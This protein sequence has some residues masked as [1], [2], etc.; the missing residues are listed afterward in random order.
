MV[1]QALTALGIALGMVLTF[2]PVAAEQRSDAL[3]LLNSNSDA[4][5]DFEHF[6]KPWL[7]HFG[8]P[9]TALDIAASSVE[10]TIGDHAVI[11][12]S[13]RRLDPLHQYL[14]PAEETNLSNAINAGTGLVNFDN[15]LSIDA[16]TPRYAFVQTIFGFGYGGSPSGAGVSFPSPGAHYITERHASGSSFVTGS[17][18]LAGITLPGSV[19]TVAT[20]DSGPFLAVTTHGTGRAVQW[21]SYDWMSYSVK[22]PM[23]GLDDLVWR[24][25]VWAA[26]KPF[27]M[28]GL[29]PFVTLRMDDDSGPF[30]WIH[31]ANEFGI[32]PYTSVFFHDI[33][34]SEAADLSALTHAG[35]ATV[36]I[37]AFDY[38]WFF[39][40]NDGAGT[41]YPDATIDDYFAEGTAWHLAKNIPISKYVIPHKY[42]FGS[43]VLQGLSDWGVEFILTSIGPDKSYGDSWIMNGPFRRYEAGGSG[44]GHPVYYADFIEFPDQPAFNGRFFNCYT[45]IRDDATY[46]WYPNMNDVPGT[47][48]RG[49]RQT[50]RAL[51]AMAL[52]ALFTHAPSVSGNWGASGADNWRA[53]LAGITT[54]LAPYSPLYVTTDE[55][56]RYIRA[57]HNSDISAAVYDPEFNRLTATFSGTTDMPTKFYV[58]GGGGGGAITQVLIDVPQFSGSTQVSFDVPGPLSR[59]DVSPNPAS[60][61]AGGAQQ[62]AAA[63]YDANG[64]PIPNLQFTWGVVNGGGTIDGSGRFTAGATFGT[65]TNTVAASSGG[66]QGFATVEVRE[67]VL[68]HFQFAQITGPKY[69]NAPFTVTITARDAAGNQVPSF[70]GSVTLTDTTGTVT[71]SSAGPF[72]GGVWRG[73]ATIGAEGTGVALTATSGDFPGVSNLFDVV[74]A[75]ACSEFARPTATVAVHVSETT[76]AHWS[77]LSGPHADWQPWH[78][79]GFLMEELR[80]DGTPFDVVSDVDIEAGRLMNGASPRYAILFS[81][82]NDCI[83]DAA[84][85]RVETFVG[86]G[87]HAF[88]GSTS[89]T[90]DGNCAPRRSGAVPPIYTPAQVIATAQ[91]SFGGTLLPGNTIDN[92]CSNNWANAI[93]D[94][95]PTWIQYEFPAAHTLSKVALVHST[96][97]E[98]NPPWRYLVRDYEVQVSTT[99]GCPEGSFVTVAI[100]TGNN[101]PREYQETTFAPAAAKCVRISMLYPSYETSPYLSYDTAHWVMINSFQAFEDGTGAPLIGHSCVTTPGSQMFALSTEMGLGAGDPILIG[102]LKRTGV[103]DPLVSHLE[104]DT[105][106]RGWK[107]AKNSGA[108]SYDHPQH[109]ALRAVPTTATVLATTESGDPILAVQNHGAGRFIYHSEFNPLAGYSMHTVAN[110]VYGFYR[111]AID[112]A[113]A[114]LGWPNVRLGAW[115]WPKLAGFITRHDH[116]SNFGFDGAPGGGDDALVAEIEAAHGVQG[117]HFLRT[118]PALPDSGAPCTDPAFGN[119]CDAAVRANILQMAALGAQFGS[120]TTDETQEPPE[121]NV[122]ASLDRLQA[123]LGSR[124]TIFVAP[125]GSGERDTTAQGLVNAGI[126]AKG[127]I[128]HGAHPHFM[129]KVDTATE[130]GAV[131]R[132]PLVDM[133]ATGYY[134]TPGGGAFAGGIWAH[135]ITSNPAACNND[136]TVRPCMQKAADLQYALGGLIN[137]YDHIGDLSLANPTPAQFGA[138][139]DY[140]QA[141]PY[142]DTT[143]PL[144]LRTWWL[145][146]DPVRV[147]TSY[148]TTPRRIV[149]VDLSC[150]ADPGPF[151][152]EVDLPWSG[153]GIVTVDGAPTTNAVID[154]RRLR[155]SAPAPARVVIAERATTCQSDAE[156]DDLDVCNGVESCNV[157]S[158]TC[159]PGT[160][161]VCNDGN[162]CTDDT[163]NGVLG[164]VFTNNQ[165]SCD[166]G[167]FCN[168]ADVCL[169]GACVH[170]TA[171]CVDPALCDEV[172]DRCLGGT[173]EDFRNTTATVAV[174]VSETTKAQWSSLG[175]PHADWQS[176]HVYGFLMEELRSDGTPFDV[177]SDVDIEAGRLMNGASPRYAILFSLAN[178]CISDAAAAQVEAFVGAGGHA[179]VGSTSWTRDGSCNLR[180]GGN[181]PPI[182]TPAQVSVT[183]QNS[184]GSTFLPGNTIDNNCN[185][186]WAN[187]IGDTL[188]TWIQY[189]FPAV[190]TL[191]KIA[192]VHSTYNET[193]PPWRYLVRNYEVQV[194]TTAGCPDGSFV[195]V[196]T[197]TGN[198]VPREYQ[199]TSFAP[200]A[201][202]CVRVNML[203]PSYETSPYQTYNT[204]N[205][206]MINSFQAF[207][208]GSGARLIDHSCATPPVSGLFALSTAM[209]LGAGDPILI[210]N[211]KRTGVVNPL[212]SHLENDTVVR[213]WKL[214]KNSGASSYDHP[215]HWA[216]KVMP[217]TATVLATTGSGDPILTVRNHGA[218]RFIYHSEF[219][220][221]AGYSMH[222]VANLVYGFYRK[223]ID[224]AHAALGWPSVRL[225]A[226]PW[227]KVAGFMTRHDHFAN[228]GFDGSAGTADDSDVALIEAARGVNG[229]YFLRTDTALPNSG[230]PCTD[231]A[232][233]NTCDAAAQASLLN[234]VALGAQIGSHTT[235]ESQEPSQTNVVAS[236]DRLQAYLGSR[237]TIFV[238]PGGS[239]IR[240][241]TNQGLVN[242]GIVTKGDISHGVHPHFTLKIDSATE[243]G[244]AAR[245]PLV[246]MPAT[247][248]YGTPGGGGFAGG[249]WAHEITSNPAGCNNDG[250][251][252]PCMQKAADLQYTLGGLINLYDHIGDLS[253]AN[254]TPAQFGAYIDYVQAKPYVDTTS[255][256]EL[257][258]WWLRRDPVRVTTV[259]GATG[260]LQTITVFVSCASDPGP[261][262][263]EIDLP[264]AGGAGVSVGGVPSTNFVIDGRRIRISSPAPSKVVI[265]EACQNDGQ[266]DDGT[267]CNGRE[268]CSNG[269]CTA[270]T[271]LDC[272]DGDACTTDTCSPVAG[273]QHTAICAVSGTVYYYR[274]NT[275]SAGAGGEPSVKGVENVGIG[276]IA[277]GPALVTTGGTGA[278]VTAGLH[279]NVTITSVNKYG[280]PRASD[281]RGA[282]TALDAARLAMTAVGNGSLSVN[283]KFAGDV[284]GNGTTSALDASLVARFAAGLVDHFPVTTTTASDWKFLKCGA[285]YPL[286]CVDPVY[287]F[288]PITQAETGKDLYAI[289][290]GDVTGN[291]PQVEARAAAEAGGGS[292]A[293]KPSEP[294]SPLSTVLSMPDTAGGGPGSTVF[295]PISATPG[296]GILGIDMMIRYDP[297]VVSA[298][299]VTTS[300]IATG[301]GIAA[302]LNTP[303]VIIIS[304]F[305][306]QSAMTGSGEIARIEFHAAGAPGATS[307]LTFTSASINEGA[308]PRVLDPGLFS[309]TC[310]GVAN[311]TA[312]ND[313]NVCTLSDHCSAGVC[314]GTV[315]AA[316]GEVAVVSFSNDRA[317]FAWNVSADVGAVYDVVRG[318]LATLPVG[319]G[320]GDELCAANDLTTTTFTDTD[321][322]AQGDGFWYLVRAA[323]SCTQGTFGNE[324]PPGGP[325]SARVTNTCQ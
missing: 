217:T 176:W 63:G 273:C 165:A 251:V 285:L 34:D 236:L 149:T 65:F 76:K 117:G 124:P 152:V 107:L 53:I 98:T 292:S 78:I 322:V 49:T 256:L 44:S 50:V 126:V 69:K 118:N 51:D 294:L 121:S 259:R 257:R 173:C 123:Y 56:C 204:A 1:R 198:N 321:P 160:P 287:G 67:P 92:N 130:Y 137:L 206:V 55:A 183:A 226:W 282:I 144:E 41:A 309:V 291:W 225:G 268:V 208:N 164:C 109:W 192:L 293:S 15:D 227:P 127:E 179:F 301:F 66:V 157:G 31:I 240:D 100:N 318:R 91:N 249:I 213:G 145:R 42:E 231:P 195:S 313:R 297:A 303:G 167:V 64:N 72:S 172:A 94:A 299:S 207:E 202:K 90:R 243:Y 8:I 40:F 312:C 115:P 22:G 296:D 220:P 238:A 317:T 13:H 260:P 4:Y 154:G 241:T 201:A 26:R 54:N 314:T 223:A 189:E 230:A 45:E 24:S 272:N 320:G 235:N 222:T 205:W 280:N 197:N 134:G 89:W 221:L 246:D 302:N 136:G 68:D 37:H 70:T 84:A 96:Y 62:F 108:S 175:G 184:F 43:N 169:N 211:L 185:N 17:M 105:V 174:H 210:G 266:C 125:G 264:W 228:V 258:T 295:V 159:R 71:P 39:F 215:L 104:N 308:I 275:L 265:T 32:K 10:A 135:E 319:P 131:A 110:L 316:P 156:C 239:G 14:S 229:G 129:L 248:Y 300:G 214:A 283:Q 219:N 80:S 234:V 269:T 77:S 146:R 148:A 166:D 244:A 106:V 139:I 36:S 151:S 102:N 274:D 298:A 161:L 81:L 182:Y 155:V 250:T 270:G 311:G 88:V 60:I 171:P 87:G 141:K 216:L 177:V 200:T 284:T 162:V 114:A 233:G 323:N 21:G 57:I 199:E 93:D 232:F 97:N 153:G 5:S 315:V 305:A 150:A 194:S 2:S 187:A 103:V 83:S 190:H 143:S 267:V 290:Y 35:E 278:Y 191:S 116:F 306:T 128:A 122:V 245:W 30:E 16:T 193:S 138:Y 111:K 271:P 307:A 11:I 263:V 52:S 113:H 254:P 196:A 101:V 46:E 277:A 203:Y 163:C 252:R 262:S 288:N 120:T 289:L 58:F 73:Q 324:A 181:A 47:I 253:L 212:V 18:T 224:E 255:P 186:N 247:G 178:D 86:A 12:I 119:T 304:M 310:A 158:G 74:A 33:D 142:V 140:V 99:A 279:G 147:S 132:W 95:L 168:G 6:V 261:F 112:E 25:I 19:T 286:D 7:D 188:P 276:A 79:Y 85:A 242:A 20:T 209:G 9:Y 59:I 237:P 23:Y 29:P 82:A 27:V 48:G 325:P 38:G 75:P 180:G 61:V 28:Q 170:G 133:P 3:V 281:H 218:G